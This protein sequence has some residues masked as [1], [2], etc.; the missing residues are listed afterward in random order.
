MAERDPFDIDRLRL[1]PTS[2]H[3]GRR[4][5]RAK[6]ERKFIKFPWAW[7]ERL[8]PAGLAVTYKLALHLLYL[9]WRAGGKPIKLSNVTLTGTGVTKDTKWRGLR[10]LEAAGLIRV[11]RRARRSPVVT[12]LLT[13]DR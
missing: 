3:P 11:E 1:D 6:W 7:Y 2:V 13:G 8:A 10:A 4:P 5:A 12:L 9:H